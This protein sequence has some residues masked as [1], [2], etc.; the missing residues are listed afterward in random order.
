MAVIM[1][2]LRYRGEFG[3]QT[4]VQWRCEI[5]QEGFAG[6]AGELMFPA[7]EP[8]LIEWEGK[9]KWEVIQGSMATLR[10]LSPGDRT[11]IDLYTLR[12]GNIRLDVYRNESK[13]WSGCLD[14]ELYE[15]PYSYKDM[16]EVSLKFSDFGVLKRTK[17]NLSGIV[18]IERILNEALTKA[19]INHSGVVKKIS[20]YVNSINRPE[21]MS[22]A[23]YSVVAENFTDEEGEVMWMSDVLDG[24]LQPFA[25]RIVQREG[26]ILLYD[27]NAMSEEDGVRIGWNSDDAVLGVD[28]VY[29]NVRVVFSPYSDSTLMSGGDDSADDLDPSVMNAEYADPS[30]GAWSWMSRE[31]TH[32]TNDAS[33][34]DS[35][36]SF[37]V[38]A[39]GTPNGI[40][41][42][43]EKAMGFHILPINEGSEK[44][45][46]AWKIPNCHPSHPHSVG[47]W[48]GNRLPTRTVEEVY[49]TERVFLTRQDS[50]KVA[51]RVAIELLADM[52]YNPFVDYGPQ[53]LGKFEDE[54]VRCGHCVMPVVITLY[55]EKGNVK[56]HFKNFDGKTTK[57]GEGAY[58]EWVDGPDP[59]LAKIGGTYNLS[60]VSAIFDYYAPDDIKKTAGIMNGWAKNRAAFLPGKGQAEFAYTY[61]KNRLTKI[62][63]DGVPIACPPEAGYIEIKVIAGLW[64]Y[65]ELGETVGEAQDDWEKSWSSYW[66]QMKWILYGVP[67]VE[68]CRKFIPFEKWS[69]GDIE[70]SGVSNGDAEDDLE[71]ETICGTSES[72]VPG[73]KG[74]IY[75]NGYTFHL[76]KR[77]GVLDGLE[78]L[79]IGTVCSQYGSR[80]TTLQGTVESK[81]G[82]VFEDASHEGKF[83]LISETMD[84]V[85]GNSECLYS[86]L[87]ADE[88]ESE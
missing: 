80:H 37:N 14:P 70:Y 42:I 68:V 9:E 11:Y 8:L 86:E 31:Y 84:C 34:W 55:D 56:Y 52:R 48:T 4:L 12:S 81:D 82:M 18:S 71:I 59:L 54:R 16:Y 78:K 65:D 25:M 10:L 76:M 77:G 35:W 15:E 47:V 20:T 61:N 39:I 23:D 33:T 40:K 69:S 36:Y 88:Y 72:I 75:Q 62:S 38:Y 58:G 28:K 1:M 32:D 27:L 44:V 57:A 85:S 6:E 66:N 83:L 29:N 63:Y 30:R 46:V 43:G 79:L 73:A 49:T 22:L 21:V 7:D 53:N 5:W 60:D 67:T 45:G 64:M 2:G 51:L 13:F 87:H 19:G 3:S 41:K 74:L 24:V 50:R 26:K 17:F